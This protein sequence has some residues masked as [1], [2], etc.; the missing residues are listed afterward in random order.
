MTIED[1]RTRL[2]TEVA[3]VTFTK[4]NGE[5]RV[6]IC[7]TKQDLLPG[8]PSKFAGPV[9]DSV[10][11]VWDIESDGWRSFRFDSISSINSAS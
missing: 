5:K 8:E 3:T 9:S 7:T 6:M 4:K 10:V 1:L 2:S 11:T